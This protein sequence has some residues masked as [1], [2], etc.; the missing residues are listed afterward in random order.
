VGPGTSYTATGAATAE[1][2]EPHMFFQIRPAGV[3]APLIDPKPVLDGW[4]QL[5]NTSIFRAKGKNPFLGTSPTVGQVLLAS[6]EQLEQ[7]VLNDPGIHLG[8]CGHEDVQTGQID[9][10]VL[11]TLEF[12]SVS[13]LRPT[14]S[15]LAC[16]R[17]APADAKNAAETSA[18][19]AVD[20]TAINGISI[21]GGSDPAR[22]GSIA[23]I[24]VRKL[25]TLQ[26]T[27]RP[28]Q[29]VSQM[30]Y[31]GAPNT[32]ALPGHE[33]SIHVAFAPLQ[34]AGRTASDAHAADAL[35]SA[36]TPGQWIQLIAR[37]SEIPDPKVSSGPSAAAIPDQPGTPGT[38]EREADGN[39]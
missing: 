11:A 25:L 28:S 32:L 34:S 4:V 2:D 20:I 27:M 5:E 6:K 36:I 35:S 30:S 31:P 33:K 14:V 1:S 29:I 13:G 24:T 18:G 37:L 23:D 39:R 38:S 9:R 17:V 10:R 19:D 15:S 8:R 16:S 3:G 22:P 21:A 12:L 26:G 7:Q